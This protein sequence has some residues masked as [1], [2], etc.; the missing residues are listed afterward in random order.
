ME[1]LDIEQWYVHGYGRPAC[2]TPVP[3]DTLYLRI[4]DFGGDIGRC[5]E[6]IRRKHLA[7]LTP[8]SRLA[9][10]LQTYGFASK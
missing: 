10:Q 3:A 7:V 4:D 6:T 9:P 8:G 1:R 5:L 2:V